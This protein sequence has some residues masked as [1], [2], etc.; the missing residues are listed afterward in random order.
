[1]ATHGVSLKWSAG[2]KPSFIEQLFEVL[3]KRELLNIVYDESAQMD[4]GAE[5][6][7]DV[8]PE[9]LAI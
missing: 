6:V 3:D 4:A 2:G 5:V 9:V 8:P 1:M 7:D